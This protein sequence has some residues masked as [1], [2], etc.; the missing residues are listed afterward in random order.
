MKSLNK[1]QSA[2]ALET[3]LL[4]MTL[5]PD[6]HK[7]AQRVIDEQIG[8]DRLIEPGDRENLPYITC[9]VKEVLRYVYPVIDLTLVYPLFG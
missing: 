9:L 3:F 4:A 1:S 2:A 8:G 6:V 7:E 5:N